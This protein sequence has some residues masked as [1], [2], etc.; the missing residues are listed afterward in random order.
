MTFFIISIIVL[1]TIIPMVVSSGLLAKL[2]LGEKNIGLA[3]EIFDQDESY[4][5]GYFKN[6]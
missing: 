4:S 2:L 3:T 1:V 6:L 5:L